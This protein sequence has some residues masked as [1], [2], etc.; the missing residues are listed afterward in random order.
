MIRCLFVGTLLALLL[1]GFS[2]GCSK[3]SGQPTQTFERGPPASAPIKA[4][5]PPPPPPK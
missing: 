2:V 5:P 1:L 4:P 3:D